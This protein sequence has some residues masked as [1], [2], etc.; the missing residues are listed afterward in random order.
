MIE[1][2]TITLQETMEL[3]SLVEWIV[4]VNVQRVLNSLLNIAVIIQK[5]VIVLNVR[6]T[7]NEI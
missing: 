6:V 5:N 1:H 2:W 4:I 3:I 7:V